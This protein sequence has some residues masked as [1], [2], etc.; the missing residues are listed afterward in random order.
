MRFHLACAVVTLTILM[1]CAPAPTLVSAP[2]P[3][4]TR[5]AVP[6]TTPTTRPTETPAPSATATP[7]PTETRTPTP[8]ATATT[9][10]TASPTTL[11]V[12]PPCP[13]W[14]VFPEAGKG[15]LV[16]ENH[17]GMDNMID[18]AA[19][20]NW[21][22]LMP[23]K[24]D[25]IPSRMVLQLSPGNYVFNTHTVPVKLKGRLTVS[26]KAGEM[27]ISPIYLNTFAEVLLPLEVPPGCK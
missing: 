18:A 23:A 27:W 8:T 15:L 12:K 17:V 24:K 5:I 2:R 13:E 25:D 4:E 3:A 1:A 14:F 9:P 19:P 11:V 6:T 20:L 16:I 10:P 22:R 21:S 7:R 26:I